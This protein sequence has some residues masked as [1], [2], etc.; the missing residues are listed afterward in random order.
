[1]AKQYY[2]KKIRLSLA[3]TLSGSQ[4]MEKNSTSSLLPQPEEAGTSST[5]TI[6]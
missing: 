5:W 3:L 4:S 1:M 6:L 2:I